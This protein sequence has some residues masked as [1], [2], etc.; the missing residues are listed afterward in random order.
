METPQTT[1][2]EL[3]DKVEHLGRFQDRVELPATVERI[4]EA[5]LKDARALID[6]EGCALFQVGDPAQGF[7]LSQAEPAGEAAAYRKEIEAQIEYGIFP[8]ALKRRQPALTPSFTLAQARSVILLP[9]A[10]AKTTLGMV[11]A[12]TPLQESLVTQE[13]LRLLSVLARQCSLVMENAV[14]YEKLLRDKEAIEEA[15]KKVLYL[16]QHDALTGCHN[17]GHMNAELPRELRR[18]LRYRRALSLA[19]CDIDHFKTV[20]DTHGHACG[21]A[22][23]QQFVESVRELV[24]DSDWLARYGGE[25]FLLVLPETTLENATRLAERLRAHIAGRA[26]T[27]EA[28]TISITASFGVVGIGPDLGIKNLAPETL[29]NLADER[30]YQAKKNGRNQVVSGPFPP[31]ADTPSSPRHS[32]TAARAQG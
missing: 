13:K 20:N 4:W 21:D 23:L 31:S 10:T 8:W 7:A 9:L 26:F 2:I 24:R 12:V 25:E 14:L 3:I 28:E 18:C 30:L 17:R 1:L 15:N 29:L 27:W 16:S 19:M 5:F 11:L 6:V 32:A 22:I